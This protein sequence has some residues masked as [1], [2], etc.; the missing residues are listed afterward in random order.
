MPTIT[1]S[2]VVDVFSKSGTPKATNVR[3]IKNRPDYSPATDFYRPLRIAL[4]A[5][6]A[7]GKDRKA[8]DSILPTISDLKKIKIYNELVEGYKKYWGR[9]DISWFNPPRGT[10]SHSGVDV[11]VNPELGLVIDGKR[12]VIK[13]YLKTDE[14]TKQ[15][16][17]LIPALM[18]ISLRQH[19]QKD[20]IV[21]LL[22][23]RKGKLHLLGTSIT[24]AT[25]M[26][27]AELAYIAT[28]WPNI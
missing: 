15:R 19:L 10:Y 2:D 5:L 25:A 11:R 9:K 8:L 17:E 20:D 3:H 28:L 22:D 18:E 7:N 26:V 13:L 16:I 14:I 4:T 1:L 21:G 27:N 23:V 12:S 6:H 24:P